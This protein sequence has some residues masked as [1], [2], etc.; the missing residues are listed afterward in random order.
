MVKHSQ[1]WESSTQ[2]SRSMP[3]TLSSSRILLQARGL[4]QEPED[5]TNSA[6]QAWMVAAWL[7][8]LGAGPIRAVLS[9]SSTSVA[10]YVVCCHDSSDGIFIGPSLWSSPSSSP[11]SP[12]R[13]PESQLLPSKSAR[14]RFQEQSS[15]GMSPSPFHVFSCWWGCKIHW[16][17]M[18]LTV[19][20]ENAFRIFRHIN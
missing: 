5:G 15:A 1:A 11:S 7:W 4:L 2:D 16:V 14:H 13:R 3:K 12:S 8:T 10:M 17:S 18:Y 9:V 20:C 19:F 6:C